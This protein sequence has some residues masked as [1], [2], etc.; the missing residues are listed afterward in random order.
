MSTNLRLQACADLM[1]RYQDAFRHAWR[2][3]AKMEAPKRVPHE[4]QFLP[5]ALALQETPVSPAPRVAMW[6]IITFAVLTL[7]WAIFGRMDVVATAEGRIVPN[8]RTKT[9]QSLETASVK[10]IHVTDGQFVRAGDVLIELDATIAQA[11]RERVLSD[12]SVANLQVQRGRALLVALD[13][14]EAPVLEWPG[15]INEQAY[16][17]AQQQLHGQYNEYLARMNRIEAELARREAEKRSTRVLVSKLEQTVPIARRRA[18]DYKNLVAKKFV[19]E[20][21]YLELEQLRIEQ[22]ADLANLRSRMGEIEAGIREARAMSEEVIAEL[23][24]MSLDS[25]ADG[26]QK[27]AILEQELL[28]AD[29]RGRLMTLVSPVDGTVQQLATHTVGGVVTPAQ[30]LM[31]IVPGD[32]PLEVEAFI[33]NKDIGFIKVNQEAEIKI[34][35]FQYTKYGTI[36]AWVTSVSHDAIND[37]KRGLIYSA[38]VKMDSSTI[39]VDGAEVKLSPGMAVSVEVKT[40][41][42]RVIEYFLSPF[43]QYQDESLRER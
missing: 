11:D 1:R 20:H 22:E 29:S 13:S 33:E 6:T 3:R 36:L 35:T 17:E 19:S 10:S 5:A 14:G 16:R 38:R 28:K 42:R 23:R 40:G 21:G 12:L 30:P 4:A 2:H 7:I 43:M 39:N 27:V 31:V 8:D 25:I 32:N 9:I 26:Q 37:E 41:K 34:E 24:R 18:E 15:T